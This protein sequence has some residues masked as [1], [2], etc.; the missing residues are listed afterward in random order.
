MESLLKKANELRIEKLDP[1]IQEKL[2]QAQAL[3]GDLYLSAEK[4]MKK[5]AN[6]YSF[7]SR[8]HVFFD[9]DHE[10]HSGAV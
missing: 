2:D 8:D 3:L 10:N 9:G 5:V 6:D 4:K 1:E 7:L